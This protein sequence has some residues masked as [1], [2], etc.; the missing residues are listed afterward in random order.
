M[1]NRC[2]WNVRKADRTRR[3]GFIAM[4]CFLLMA[5]CIACASHTYGKYLQSE[6]KTFDGVNVAV[7]RTQVTTLSSLNIPLNNTT[8][9]TATTNPFSVKRIDKENDA[10]GVSFS[11]S[12]FLKVPENFPDY[13]SVNLLEVNGD[14]IE[15]Q[16]NKA[17]NTITFGQ[18]YSFTLSDTVK[19]KQF[20]LE[21]T[22]ADLFA[23]EKGEVEVGQIKL[24]NIQ[25][26]VHSEQIQSDRI[27]EG[28]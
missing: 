15:G 11:Y 12:I 5:G 10:I 6:S 23:L 2:L 18:D 19:L 1:I 16:F 13:I 25:I 20:K 8:K 22:I 17:D 4:G 28:A 14:T 26:V 21:F 9:T 3:M 7:M 24:E 27:T